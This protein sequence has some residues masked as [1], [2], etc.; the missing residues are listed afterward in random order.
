M[1]VLEKLVFVIPGSPFKQSLMFWVRTEPTRVK[2][3]AR[4]VSNLANRL[5]WKGLSATNT[6][7]Y[8]EHL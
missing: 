8:H 3:L 4:V 5:S 6:L 7:D 1:N 2:Q